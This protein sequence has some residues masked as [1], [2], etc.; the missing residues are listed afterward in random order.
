MRL[1]IIGTGST[2]NA[3]LLELSG[4]SSL[5]LDAGLP[6]RQIIQAIDKPAQLTA[7][8][9]THEHMDHAKAA[10][11]LLERG[12]P[13]MMSRGTADALK[14]G[15][16]PPIIVKAG[17]K[18]E[19]KG[20]TILPFRTEHDVAEPLGFLIRDNVTGEVL[21]YATDTYYLH[22]L[23]PGVTYWLIECNYCTEVMDGQLVSGG[24]PL[25][26]RGRLIRSHM[27]LD[28]LLEAFQANDLTMTRK[29]ILCHLSD[30]RSDEGRMIREVS[31]LTGIDTAAAHA[32]DV[33]D[34]KDTPF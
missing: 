4:G 5:L 33:Y 24:I 29:I 20:I 12:I 31:S 14:L 18:K 30:A 27:S 22:N 6:I 2:G 13:V 17:D 11:K 3:Y 21:L 26:M 8:L 28:H 25:D 1:H 10:A 19:L 32:G 15:I 16:T 7:C 23:F 9:V 34:L